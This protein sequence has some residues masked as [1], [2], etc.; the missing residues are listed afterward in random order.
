MFLY[1]IDIFFAIDILMNFITAF[2][3]Q[4]EEIIDDR[5]SIFNNYLTGWFIVDFVSVFPLDLIFQKYNYTSPSENFNRFFRIIRFFRIFSLRQIHHLKPTFDYLELYI[6]FNPKTKKNTRFVYEQ[7]EQLMAILVLFLITSHYIACI[8]IF[9]GKESKS[10]K[11]L[12]S[13]D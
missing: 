10:E 6:N 3:N 1:S 12:D 4:Y 11:F 13:S 2:E 9:V 7:V 5:F 8:W